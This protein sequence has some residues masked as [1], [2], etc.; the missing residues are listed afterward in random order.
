MTRNGAR[1]PSRTPSRG[2]QLQRTPGGSKRS[3]SISRRVATAVGNAI[4]PGAG[5]AAGL[6]YD[7]G[8]YMSSKFTS[9]APRN[10]SKT[11]GRFKFNSAQAKYH[12]TGSIGG[13]FSKVQEKNKFAKYANKGVYHVAECNGTV[14]DP[15]CVYLSHVAVDSY[16]MMIQLTN[17]LMRKLFEKSGVNITNVDE[18]LPHLSFADAS[19]YTIELTQI[20]E[21]TGIESLTATYL[22]VAGSTIASISNL[23][24]DRFIFFSSGSGTT[25]GALGNRLRLFRLI[26]YTQDVNTTYQRIFKCAINLEDEIICLKGVSK[27]KLQ[28]RTLAADGSTSREDVSN[29]PLVGRRYEFK[30]YPK[31]RDKALYL[32]NTVLANEGVN[33]VRASQFS[34]GTYKEPPLPNHFSNCKGSSLIQLE[35]GEIKYATVKYEKNMGFLTFLTKV[36]ILLDN[37]TPARLHDAPFPSQMFAL[38]DMINVNP[39]SNI[40]IA[41]EINKELGI[42]FKTNKKAKA[43]TTFQQATVSNNP[44]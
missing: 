15:D 21:N 39:T 35:P 12:T 10:R 4:Y 16:S 28:N 33:L 37:V 30:T 1:T 38:E 11:T 6:A 2:R 26:L 18:P 40:S 14:S 41:Y 44:P 22:T 13:K 17:A 8:K 19:G 5:T 20:D 32:M 29:N 9:K 36:H 25:S 24:F 34:G 7:A 27:M 23:F 3:R 43:V 42:Y 31:G